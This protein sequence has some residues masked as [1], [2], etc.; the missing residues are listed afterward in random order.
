[1]SGE[2]RIVD[3]DRLSEVAAKLQHTNDKTPTVI[4]KIAD[5]LADIFQDD[6]YVEKDFT[7]T[8]DLENVAIRF[9]HQLEKLEKAKKTNLNHYKVMKKDMEYAKK[10]LAY[11]KELE[12][13]NKIHGE[14]APSGYNVKE[15]YKDSTASLTLEGVAIK[16]TSI[17]L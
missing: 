6:H 17:K 10:R 1:M 5:D 2:K 12:F 14:Y 8:Q 3:K 13:V 15:Q 16:Q 11:L 7:V 9:A 4:Q